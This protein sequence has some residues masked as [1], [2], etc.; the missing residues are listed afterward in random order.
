ME[1][2]KSRVLKFAGKAHQH[3]LAQSSLRILFENSSDSSDDQ[4]RKTEIEHATKVFKAHRSA[5]DA[6]HEVITKS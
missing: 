5:L 6:D 1:M 4:V 2:T 3:K